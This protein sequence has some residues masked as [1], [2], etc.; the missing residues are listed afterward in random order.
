VLNGKVY[1]VGGL[2]SF[3]KPIRNPNIDIYDPTSNSWSTISP[4]QQTS[5]TY[6]TQTFDPNATYFGLHGGDV[7]HF[8]EFPIYTYVKN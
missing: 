5:V 8:L 3:S 1:V 6:Q 4:Q 7:D 2:A